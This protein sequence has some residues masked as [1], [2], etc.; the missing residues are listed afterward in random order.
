MIS[1]SPLLSLQ[2]YHHHHN[3]YNFY[4]LEI[5]FIDEISVKKVKSIVGSKKTL[6]T[7]TKKLHRLVISWDISLKKSKSIGVHLNRLKIFLLYFYNTERCQ[8]VGTKVW[9]RYSLSM[10]NKCLYGILS[11]T[12][13]HIYIYIYIYIYMQLK[14]K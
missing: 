6:A 2:S 12:H 13:A 1:L 11:Y 14:I 3:W 9:Q 8:Y 7:C 5:S 10:Q 4:Y